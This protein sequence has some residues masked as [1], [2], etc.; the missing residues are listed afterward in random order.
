MNLPI[1]EADLT[2]LVRRV[3]D[4]ILSRAHALGSGTSERIGYTEPEAASLLGIKPH[5][6]RDARLRGEIRAKRVGKRILYSHA[7][8]ERL[9][10]DQ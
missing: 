9:L 4:E 5:V 1:D 8:L 2:T 6:L 10:N 3:V 7:E